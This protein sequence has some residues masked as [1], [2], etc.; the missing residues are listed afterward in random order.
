MSAA[1]VMQR[2]LSNLLSAVMSAD[3][4]AE[5]G[6]KPPARVEGEVWERGSDRARDDRSGSWNPL[7]RRL[8]GSVRFNDARHGRSMSLIFP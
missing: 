4:M 5:P 6:R 7:S 1:A 3:T 2:E 8:S